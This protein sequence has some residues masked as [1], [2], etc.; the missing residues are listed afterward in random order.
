MVVGLG[1]GIA[2]GKSTVGHYFEE[3]GAAVIDADMVAR[4][5]VEPGRSEL[6]QI[7]A[8]FGDAFITT[9]GHMDR[10]K[11]RALVFS[12]PEKRR[13]LESILHPAIGAELFRQAAEAEKTHPYVI[14]M[15]PLLEEMGFIER[16]QRVVMVDATREQQH[17]RL[18]QRDGMTSDGA[19]AM[20]DAQ[21]SREQR[22][23]VADDLVDN[24]GEGSNIAGQVAQ[25]HQL[26]SGLACDA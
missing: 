16:V 11:M 22:S 13:Q 14:V 26:Y 1:G 3:L 17:A 25:L 12:Q 5:V 20:I 24:T 9:D 2:S 23:S 7:A 19:N 6:L 10:A 8:T 15:V 4:L 18:M 21:S